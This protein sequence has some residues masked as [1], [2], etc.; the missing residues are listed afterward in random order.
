MNIEGIVTRVTL[1]LV[2]AYSFAAAVAAFLLMPHRGD[3]PIAYWVV[4]PVA[5]VVSTGI[6]YLL[7]RRGRA[8][9][10]ASIALVA[11]YLALVF[12]V[13]FTGLGLRSYALTL[14]CVLI[15]AS[16]TL[17]GRR[18]GIAATV[19]GIATA[20][21][22]YV[23][24]RAGLV[25]DLAVVRGI[26][27]VNIVVVY[28]IAFAAVGTLSLAFSH[29]FGTAL[30]ATRDQE[31]RFRHLLEAAP[32]GYLLHRDGRILLANERAAR[33]TGHA[34]AESMVGLDIY[35]LLPGADPLATRAR[36]AQAMALA[37]GQ[38]LDPAEH[39]IP[40]PLGGTRRISLLTMRIE[41]AD[42][43]ALLTLVRDVTRERAAA[44]ALTLA[45]RDAEA[46]NR[47]KSEFLATM[48][49][50]IRTPLNA[51]VGLA[52]LARGPGLD[53]ARRADYLGKIESASQ[54]LLELI[55]DILDF[56]KIE[57]G[58]LGLEVTDFSPRAEIARLERLHGVLA[59][60]KGL[61]LATRV[62]ASV[63]PWLRGDP[64]RLRQVV[65][66]FLSN[67]V[68]FTGKGRIDVRLTA[69]G[70]ARLRIEVEDTGIGIA[71]DRLADV[72]LPF[73]QADSSTTRRYG[74][75]GLG[76]SVCRKLV[77]L[78]GGT[79]GAS[80]RPGAGS[81]FWVEI[82]LV[83]GRPPQ[84]PAAVV[85]PAASA[86]L[87]GARVLL[88]EDNEINQIVALAALEDL[89][90]ETTLASD[91]EAA[92]AMLERPG[93]TF[94]AVLMDLHMPGI[95]GLE[96]T[97]RLRKRFPAGTL[98]V[99]ALTAAAFDDDR[100]RCLEAGMDD[101]LTKPF[102]FG[103]LRSVLARCIRRSP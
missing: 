97:R 44:D 91:G 76:L 101:F 33:G 1:Q 34:S 6:A 96:T 73:T 9:L 15:A 38:T 75:T 95:D 67:A 27:P 22:L 60:G 21:A 92:L 40:G 99:I 59:S 79:L 5:V 7:A 50:E 82:P 58:A 103:R 13:V 86:P 85:E 39:E 26:H 31:A 32:L 49:H 102:E 72:F 69:P 47:A 29:A 66:N 52:Q 19:I 41:M 88:V 53:A 90:V 45:K 3:D 80:S 83:E 42:G 68:K 20:I 61:V 35:T 100:L 70:A 48:S 14:G 55:S 87:A 10:G 54:S 74:G 98:P 94:D 17:V 64:V 12:Y 18:A 36:L 65:G 46:A 81:V 8:R 23:L 28:G 30:Q 89:G 11:C 56:S 43:P 51:V 25:T 37:P 71:E 77:E 57:A 24:E 16:S 4:I 78:M 84:R 63:P 62:D 93:T 2:V